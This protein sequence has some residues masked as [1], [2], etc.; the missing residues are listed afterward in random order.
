MNRQRYSM[1]LRDGHDD[2]TLICAF[3]FL[4]ERWADSHA[5]IFNLDLGSILS[6]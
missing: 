5:L 4:N 3:K 2:F 1:V 6:L